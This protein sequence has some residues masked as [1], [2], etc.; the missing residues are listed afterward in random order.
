MMVEPTNVRTTSRTNFPG[1]F[2]AT[3]MVGQKQ[4]WRAARLKSAD[5]IFRRRTSDLS[6][7][8]HV[9][10]RDHTDPN[11][12][13]QRARDRTTVAPTGVT[14]A[15]SNNGCG[16]IHAAQFMRSTTVAMPW[17]T[18]MHMVARP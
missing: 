1:L 16:A 11:S 12:I 7:S 6:F 10:D 15:P 17:P 3:A 18:P 14:L 8:A 2:I 13:L 9:H 5:K 4:C